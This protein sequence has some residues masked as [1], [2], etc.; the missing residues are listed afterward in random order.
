MAIRKLSNVNLSTNEEE[1]VAQRLRKQV[2]VTPMNPE[3]ES[4]KSNLNAETEMQNS[5]TVTE[6]QL[7]ESEIGSA[8]FCNQDTP[9]SETVV[10]A[11]IHFYGSGN[12]AKSESDL[13]ILHF[14]ALLV[15]SLNFSAVIVW[16]SATSESADVLKKYQAELG[17]KSVSETEFTKLKTMYSSEFS[18]TNRQF[19]LK[20]SELK[21]YHLKSVHCKVR[22]SLIIE[23]L[24]SGWN[25][26][27]A[28]SQHWE[29]SKP[30]I[31]QSSELVY[32]ITV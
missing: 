22:S 26:K 11:G 28:A 2:T 18:E 20:I 7:I 17:D 14:N 32:E 25:L 12:A 6:L 3:S 9:I 27:S 10:A 31:V 16:N 23:E 5:K 19:L 15:Q 30:A 29:F 13:P 4:F 21:L 8:N 24:Q 1:T